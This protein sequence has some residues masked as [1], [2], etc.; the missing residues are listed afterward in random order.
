MRTVLLVF[1]ALLI[2]SGMLQFLFPQHR[3]FFSLMLLAGVLGLL[4][5]H[6]LGRHQPG[7]E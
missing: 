1:A 3:R 6:W 4:V 2:S 7:S 5:F